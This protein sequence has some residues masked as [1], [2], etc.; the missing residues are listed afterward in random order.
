MRCA[1]V[2]VCE[3]RVKMRGVE[4]EDGEDGDGG[5]A[6]M[7]RAFTHIRSAV[8]LRESVRPS[9]RPSVGGGGCEARRRRGVKPS[10]PGGDWA[11]EVSERGS[12]AKELWKRRRRRGRGRDPP[13][14]V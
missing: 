13:V 5:A 8:W 4:E 14:C 6:A 12:E 11:E 3:V 7:A 1:G 10:L 9:V 2:C